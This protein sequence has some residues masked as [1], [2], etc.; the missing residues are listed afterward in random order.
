MEEDDCVPV[1][2]NLLIHFGYKLPVTICNEVTEKSVLT[3]VT[4]LTVENVE[5]HPDT[6][7]DLP[8]VKLS[9]LSRSD[10]THIKFEEA[11][12][13]AFFEENPEE[14]LIAKKVKY[15]NAYHPPKC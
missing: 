13:E 3:R 14:S 10:G 12:W 5:S 9:P 6:C 11:V 2:R 4:D 15:G 7:Y 1:V 8:T